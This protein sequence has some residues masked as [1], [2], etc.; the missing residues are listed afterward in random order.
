MG[1]RDGRGMFSRILLEVH[2]VG[3]FRVIFRRGL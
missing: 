1:V 2:A 3:I